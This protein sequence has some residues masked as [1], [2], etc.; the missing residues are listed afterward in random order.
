MQKG[1]T[2]KR[3]PA[4][5]TMITGF[6]LFILTG[7]GGSKEGTN[8]HQKASDDF[9]DDLPSW[10]MEPPSNSDEYLYSVAAEVSRDL[11]MAVNK[12]KATANAD[13]ARQMENNVDVLTKRFAQETGMNVDSKILTEFSETTKQLARQRLIGVSEE[14]KEIRNEDGVFRAYVLMKLPMGK[15][16]EIMLEQIKKENELL[17]ALK[18]SKAYKELDEAVE[19]YDEQRGK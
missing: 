16:K 7:C 3:M 13:L 2:M 5:L 12:A 18:A 14:K 1:T 10:Y 9:V 8:I 15:M 17:T 4:A 19:K 11:Q 6:G